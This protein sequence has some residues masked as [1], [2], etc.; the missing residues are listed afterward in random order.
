MP[1]SLPTYTCNNTHTPIHTH[2]QSWPGRGKCSR[3][4]PPPCPLESAH[5]PPRHACL[6]LRAPEPSCRPVH[7]YVIYIWVGVVGG[8]GGVCWHQCVRRAPRHNCPTPTQHP[9][10]RQF[11]LRLLTCSVLDWSCYKYY[12]LTYN[13][14]VSVCV[15]ICIYIWIDIGKYIY[16]QTYM[17]CLKNLEPQ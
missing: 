5:P 9:C 6:L 12:L 1:P 10:L 7:I 17:T 11:V 4:A 13:V 14:C 2:T 15:Y 8:R 3:P 16:I